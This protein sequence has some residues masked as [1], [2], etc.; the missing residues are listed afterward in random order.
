M[1][2]AKV[3]GNVEARMRLPGFDSHKLVLLQPIDFNHNPIRWI[4]IALDASSGNGG[5]G[6]GMG[7]IVTFV[8]GREAANPFVD[9]PLPV[10][11]C[12]TSIV[13]SW[14]YHPEKPE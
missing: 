7:S 9:P 11:A 13:D 14:E 1:F 8:E 2:L 10:D 12:I 3:I 4:L 6:A 5:G